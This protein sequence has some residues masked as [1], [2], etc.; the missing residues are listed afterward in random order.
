MQLRGEGTAV[1]KIRD[2]ASGTYHLMGFQQVGESL[3]VL[4]GPKAVETDFEDPPRSETWDCLVDLVKIAR[5]K[6]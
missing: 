3:A 2:S 5:L 6:A 4:F 1:I